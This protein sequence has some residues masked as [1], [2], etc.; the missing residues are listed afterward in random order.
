MTRPRFIGEDFLDFKR[1]ANGLLQVELFA[2]VAVSV[3]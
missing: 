2:G 3:H 1:V